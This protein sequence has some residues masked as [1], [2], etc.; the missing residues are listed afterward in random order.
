MKRSIAVLAALVLA[1]PLAA[2]AHVTISPDRAEAGGWTYLTFR[3]PTESDSAS[4]TKIEVHLPSDTPFTHVSYQPA[5]GWSTKVTSSTLPKPVDVMGNTISEAP[6]EITYTA[7]DGGIRPGE[8]QM[9]TVSLGPVPDTGHVV[10]PI[11]QTYS[12]GTVVEWKATPEE[13]AADDTL[14]PA[15]V[16][17]VK[18]AP[19]T[20]DHHGTGATATA[21]AGSDHTGSGSDSGL[22]IGL[23]IAALV[24]AAGAAILGALAYARSRGGETQR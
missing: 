18:D 16:L 4:T 14:E 10:I 5:P 19:P 15:P 11:T 2:S 21:A 20:G 24:L 23:S 1:A 7:T 13:V 8:V 3:A 6:T 12:D 17:W 22:P 9:F